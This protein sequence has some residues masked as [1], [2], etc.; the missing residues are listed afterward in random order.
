MSITFPYARKLIE[1]GEL[2]DPRITLQVKTRRG[3]LALQFLVDSGAD[4]TTLSINPYAELFGLKKDPTKKVVVGGVE[5]RG[6]GA[7]PLSVTMRVDRFT[8]PVRC[9]FIESSIDPLL[10]RLDFWNVFSI[11][12]DNTNLQTI[13]TPLKTAQIS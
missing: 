9:Y 12:F 4:V 8:F 11:S 13:L 7:Y 1:E 3:F 5:G 2:V 6:V 10:G